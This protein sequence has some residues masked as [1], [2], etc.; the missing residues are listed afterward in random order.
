MDIFSQMMRL[1]FDVVAMS[2]EPF[3]RM[4][5]EAERTAGMDP[6]RL[7]P[8]ALTPRPIPMLSAPPAG[9]PMPAVSASPLLAMP[10]AP[11]KDDMNDNL[12][13]LVRYSIVFTKPDEEKILNEGEELY[14]LNYPTTAEELAA[15]LL[16]TWVKDNQGND[17]IKDPKDWRYLKVRLHIVER[18][19]VEDKYYDRRQ[20]QAQEKIAGGLAK[21]FGDAE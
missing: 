1:P 9:V 18:Y 15:L 13:K 16:L 6:Q 12:V 4:A 11:R 8:A 10:P 20:T 2:I 3:L 21:A 14:V 19:A 7:L 17:A 5:R